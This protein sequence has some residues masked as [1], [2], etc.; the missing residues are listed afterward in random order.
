MQAG[1]I[2]P[3]GDRRWLIRWYI[4]R[5]GGRRR[6]GSQAVEGTRRDA[7]RA[8]REKL[9]NRDDGHAIPSP[10]SIPTLAEYVK[11]WEKTE[12]AAKLRERT[13][14][15]YLDLLTRRVTP[16]LGAERLDQ[17][18][19]AR[20]EDAVVAPLRAAGHVRTARLAVCALSRVYRAALKDRS[21]GLRGNPCSGVEI[22]RK[23]R[24]DVKPLDADERARFRAAIAGTD[25]EALW[26]LMMLTGL[27]P[28]EALALDWTH[29]DLD[30][31]TLR[32]VRT[33]DCKARAL[34]DDTKRPTRRR[35]VPLAPELR[36]LLRK[37]WLAAGRPAADL[38]FGGV[39]GEPLDLDN[40]RARHFKPALKRA[41]IKR[42][43]RVYDLR[44]G[45]ATAALEAGVD[46]RT[47][48]DLMGHSG[49]RTVL[50]VYQHASDERKREA[51][52]RIAM[53]LGTVR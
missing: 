1:Q 2:I 10:S 41:E 12:S 20:I 4:G 17:I 53:E 14:R 15:D 24:G 25:H 30:A 49:T 31:G 13:R 32:V 3:R 29:L 47:V 5:E 36:A 11:R 35:T 19:A 37:R 28:G 42:P 7:Q 46:V 52:R 39:N 23:P 44:H 40:L 34:V 38:V 27:G 33:L 50:D 16:A 6:Y 18:H 8:L 26:L 48:A 9:K 43:L 45:F 22:G 21:L 51:T